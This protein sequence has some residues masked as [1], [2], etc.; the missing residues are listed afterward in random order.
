[1]PRPSPA[2]AALLMLVV[3]VVNMGGLFL[4]LHCRSTC[5]FSHPSDVRLLVINLDISRARLQRFMEIA[6]SRDIRHVERISGVLVIG[7]ETLDI[8]RHSMPPADYGCALAHRKAWQEVASGNAPWAV[9][10]E[11]DCEP[12]SLDAITVFPLIPDTCDMV[13][14]D[15][16]TVRHHTPMCEKY[17]DNAVRRV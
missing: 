5:S 8:P 6:E 1:M 10:M 7:N 9:V 3:V 2:R 17:P 16:R 11:D 4:F 13:M 12:L 14:L 15:T